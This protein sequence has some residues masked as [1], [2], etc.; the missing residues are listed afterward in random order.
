[1][2]VLVIGQAFTGSMGAA[3]VSPELTVAEAVTSPDQH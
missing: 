1:M 3:P 2:S